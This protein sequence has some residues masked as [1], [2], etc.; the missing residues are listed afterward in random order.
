MYLAIHAPQ[1]LI[2]FW[3]VYGDVITPVLVTIM[4]SILTYV[5]IKIKTEAK[6]TAAKTDLQIKA[7][8]DFAEKETGREQIEAQN[9][10]IDALTTTIGYLSNMIDLAFQNSALTPEI[11]QK[12]ATLN[13]KIKYGT[14]DELVAEQ[15]EQ[16]KLLKEQIETLTA[17][18]ANNTVEVIS[19]EVNKRI[20]R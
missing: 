19:T 18:V 4:V 3:S 1:W 8:K 10:K 9:K 11:K 7:M 15:N 13:E 5:A 16:I 6:V 12:L 20:R 2:D 14:T 17:T